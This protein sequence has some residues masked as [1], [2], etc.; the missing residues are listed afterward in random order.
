VGGEER[1]REREEVRKTFCV[2]CV[3]HVQVHA[4]EKIFKVLGISRKT[5]VQRNTSSQQREK[6]T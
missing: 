2:C 1:E 5:G 3:V 6:T 4:R